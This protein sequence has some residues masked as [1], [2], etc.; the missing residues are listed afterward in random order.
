MITEDLL[1]INGN[2]TLSIINVN[3]HDLIRIVN[4]SDSDAIL[5][6][7]MLNKYILLTGDGNH[8][9]KQWKIEGDNLNLISTEENAHK[10]GI[11]T[12][13]KIGEGHVLSGSRGEI[14]IW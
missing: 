2:Q 14:K 10:D 9:I 11:F 1:L 13:L 12:L 8:K 3:Q 7:C 4:V 6:C 5:S